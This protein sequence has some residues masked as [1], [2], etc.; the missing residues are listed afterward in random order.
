MNKPVTEWK[1]Q[2]LGWPKT[3]NVSAWNRPLPALAINGCLDRWHRNSRVFLSTEGSS[4][5][6]IV[7][8]ASKADF[9]LAKKRVLRPRQ[10]DY[11][12][13]SMGCRT[14]CMCKHSRFFRLCDV[15]GQRRGAILIHE[16]CGHT[17]PRRA[18]RVLGSGTWRRW[19]GNALPNLTEEYADRQWSVDRGNPA[20]TSASVGR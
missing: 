8:V 11:T 10:R 19:L 14:T 15:S 5:V 9:P 17:H 13:T 20:T 2:P 3:F 16:R 18:T 4:G 7:D 12:R 6:H 1:A